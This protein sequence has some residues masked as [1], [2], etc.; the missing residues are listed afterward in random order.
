MAVIAS[1]NAADKTEPTKAPRI[2]KAPCT[3]PTESAESATP[4]PN[5]AAKASDAK[6]SRVDLRASCS[7]PKPSPSFSAPRIANGPMQNTS[8]ASTNP[9]T[10]RL[11]LSSESPELLRLSLCCSQ[12]PTRSSRSSI[13]SN[14]PMMPPISKAPNT[15]SSGAAVP[16]ESEKAVLVRATMLNAPMTKV[17]SPSASVTVS[18]VR[19]GN[20]WPTSTPRP[21]PIRIATILRIVPLPRMGTA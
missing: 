21:D 18:R 19:C 15:I 12:L 10:N 7:I 8:D 11:R 6:P 13:C 2:V 16:T 4:Q 9:S 17:T 1:I 20:R 3:M 14:D 5:D